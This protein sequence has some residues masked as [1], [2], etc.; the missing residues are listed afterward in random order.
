MS[1]QSGQVL[2]A[3][4]R[5]K[6][7]RQR[8]GCHREGDWECGVR[9]GKRKVVYG[10]VM[11]RDSYVGLTK[12]IWK[13]FWCIPEGKPFTSAE[14]MPLPELTPPY[15]CP[16]DP[17][18]DHSA[19]SSQVVTGPR[20]WE[21]LSVKVCEGHTDTICYIQKNCFMLLPWSPLSLSIDIWTILGPFGFLMK[22]LASAR[23]DMT[24]K[25]P[26]DWCGGTFL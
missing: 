17:M 1:L 20:Q 8:E 3:E 22:V 6:C 14:D 15:F 16:P 25:S 11:N 9:K 26:L 13:I 10:Q 23:S 2:G 24:H 5:I 19:M 4:T 7:R 12:D 18:T 21:L